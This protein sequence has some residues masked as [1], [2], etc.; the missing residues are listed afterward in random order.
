MKLIPLQGTCLELNT[1]PTISESE[2]MVFCGH[3]AMNT[4]SFGISFEDLSTHVLLAGGTGSGK[5]NL[6]LHMIKKIKEIMTANDVMLIFDAK[7]DFHQFLDS[8]DYVISNY[9]KNRSGIV[10]WNIFM[11]IVA[12]GWDKAEIEINAD[13]VAEVIFADNIAASNQP[14]FP[15]AAR[16]IFAAVLKAMCFLGM[17]DTDYRVKY[18]NNKALAVYLR[19][20]NA[21][22]LSDFIGKF[23]ELTGVLKYVG[24]GESD[25]AL[26][27]FAE[28]QAVTGRLFVKGFGENGRFSVRKTERQKNGKTLLVEYDASTGKSLQPIYRVLVDLF[29]KEALSPISSKGHVYAIFDELKMLSHLNHLEDALNFA[30]SLGLVVIAGIQSMEQLYEVYGEYGGKNIASAFQTTFCFRT[31]NA[32]TREYIKGVH[33]TNVCTMHYLNNC[34]KPMEEIRTGC[35]VEDWD[36]STLRCGE[37]IIGLPGKAPFKFYIER[38]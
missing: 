28:L 24:S 4:K 25:Q 11:D 23:P 9:K 33:G 10:H 17:H 34:N 18:L 30:R 37:A 3:G 20:L 16:D 2:S 12:D 6:I 14:F 27:V 35:T 5:T 19:G 21:K 7:N 31:N 13:E 32:A 15:T 1:P 26:G 29:L 38:F 22:R 36:I 8:E